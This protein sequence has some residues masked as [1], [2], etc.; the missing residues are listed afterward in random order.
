MKKTIL[1]ILISA[2]CIVFL[3]NCAKENLEYSINSYDAESRIQVSQDS[4]DSD[5]QG[6]NSSGVDE[7]NDSFIV[8]HKIYSY[9]ENNIAIVD[10]TN[11]T[12]TDYSFTIIG[13][14]LNE[15]GE[16]LKT[17]IAPRLTYVL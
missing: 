17:E 16:V 5:S 12:K 2:L 4:T 1:A 10:I 7:S 6:E 8:K 11:E 15:A 13:S 3:T 9:E 14:Y